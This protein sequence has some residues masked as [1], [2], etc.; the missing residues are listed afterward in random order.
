MLGM[1]CFFHFNLTMCF[2][3]IF[4]G[5]VDKWNEVCQIDWILVVGINP[6]SSR[7]SIMN[8]VK[9]TVCGCW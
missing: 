7:Q 1:W 8:L 5:Q 4:L 3:F 6:W 2:K 9:W